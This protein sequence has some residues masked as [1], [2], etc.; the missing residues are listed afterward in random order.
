MINRK[1]SVLRTTSMHRLARTVF[2]AV[3]AAMVVTAA[4]SRRYPRLVVFLRP[5]SIDLVDAA[6]SRQ[7]PETQMDH[8]LEPTQTHRRTLAAAIAAIRGIVRGLAAEQT[9]ALRAAAKADAS[10][11]NLDEVRALYVEPRSTTGSAPR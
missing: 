11:Q 3:A 8:I 10:R 6:N 4:R 7:S 5:F 9:L 2:V 1:Y